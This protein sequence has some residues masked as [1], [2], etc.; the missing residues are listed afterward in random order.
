MDFE[1]AKFQKST[2]YK[3]SVDIFTKKLAN[4]LNFI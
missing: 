2:N 3:K 4:H 1:Q